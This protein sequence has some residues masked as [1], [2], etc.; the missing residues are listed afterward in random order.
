MSSNDIDALIESLSP[1][2]IKALTKVIKKQT[3]RT[4]DSKHRDNRM[5]V[6]RLYF[7]AEPSPYRFD[8]SWKEY[9]GHQDMIREQVRNEV[10]N[11]D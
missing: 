8:G 3:I 11:G 9:T 5:K 4:I 7:S 10:Y 6:N 2:Q 1:E